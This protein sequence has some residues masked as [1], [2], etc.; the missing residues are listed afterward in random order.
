[1]A[2]RDYRRAWPMPGSTTFI[3]GTSIELIRSLHAARPPRHALFDFDG[4]LSLIREGWMQIMVPMMVRILSPFAG[5]GES[6]AS[7]RALVS[8][9]VAELTGKQTIYQMI[10]LAGEIEARGGKA[11]DPLDYK[12]EFHDLLMTRIASRREGLAGGTMPRESMLV[13]GSLEILSL[14]RERGVA[15]HIASGTDEEYVLEEAR[16][17]GLDEYAPGAI[18]GARADHASFSKE[19]VIRRILD[20]NR[21][22]GASLVAFGDGYVEIADCKAVG[23]VAVGVASDEAGRSGKP[24]AWKR[25]RLIGAGADIVVPDYACARTLVDWLWSGDGS[26][27]KCRP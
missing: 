15:I 6:E 24:D 12:S 7:I 9:F 16:L 1:V 18:H 23:G 13:P 5:S 2:E 19:L 10:R 14:L 3:P 20:E 26:S 27:G 8:D 4:T 21:V 17:L 11:A 25:E 22:D